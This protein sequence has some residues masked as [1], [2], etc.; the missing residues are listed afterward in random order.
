M[1][2][3]AVIIIRTAIASFAVKGTE[4]LDLMISCDLS[5]EDCFAIV[6][7]SSTCCAAADSSFSDRK[8]VV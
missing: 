6:M 3:T 8:S 1:T 2:A 7:L 4:D 5:D